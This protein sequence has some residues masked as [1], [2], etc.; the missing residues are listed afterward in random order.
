MCG[1]EVYSIPIIAVVI[2]IIAHAIDSNRFTALIRAYNSIFSFFFCLFESSVIS[3][4]IIIIIIIDWGFSIKFT[5]LQWNSFRPRGML[6][7]SP[8]GGYKSVLLRNL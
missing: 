8:R 6:H 5:S 1:I 2:I 4:Q 3:I 7:D